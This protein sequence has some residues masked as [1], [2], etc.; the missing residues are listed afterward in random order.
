MGV[1][2]YLG[3]TWRTGEAQG[4]SPAPG[5]G[6]RLVLLWPGPWPDLGSWYGVRSSSGL[7]EAPLWGDWIYGSLLDPAPEGWQPGLALSITRDGEGLYT[8]ELDPKAT[9][10]DGTPMAPED[11]AAAFQGVK[12]DPESPYHEAAQALAEGGITWKEE[13]GTTFLTLKLQGPEAGRAL[14]ALLTMGIG[15]GPQRS[16]LTSGAYKAEKTAAGW[17]FTPRAE[18]LPPVEVKPL[19]PQMSIQDL[20]KAFQAAPLAS[21]GVPKGARLWIRPRP[22][23]GYLAMNVRV[24]PAG[25]TLTLPL[26][27]A[28]AA[29]LPGDLWQEGAPFLQPA[30]SPLPL[31]HWAAPALREEKGTQD[32]DAASLFA[33]AGY[34]RREDGRLVD[35]DGRELEVHLA[36]LE[37]DSFQKDLALKAAAALEKE[38]VR[39]D[40]M[41]MDGETF[42]R[43]VFLRKSFSL[44]LLPWSSEGESS[45]SQLLW[46]KSSFALTGGKGEKLEAL[47]GWEGWAADLPALVR[48]YGEAWQEAQEEVL[49]LPLYQPV[50]VW[51]AAP[52]V[53]LEPLGFRRP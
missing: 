33:E 29:S 31:G 21:P 38:G 26:R 36:Y 20:G 42:A 37:E 14:F 7:G 23:I 10:S 9:W 24:Q 34:H 2:L 41:P 43:Q 11:I 17:S 35:K 39:V 27:K 47:G 51:A 28:L 40:P 19:T 4:A 46:P 13:G 22:A 6:D 8:L 53:A 48:L 49:L 44:A 15:P 30:V 18:G 25:T 1:G 12:G 50:E 3:L 5:E 32:Q 52:G 16:G 45:L